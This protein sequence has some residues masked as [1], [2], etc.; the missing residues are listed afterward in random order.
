MGL[1]SPQGKLGTAV[2]WISGVIKN[3]ETLLAIILGAA[4]VWGISGKVES[5]IAAHDAKVFNAGNAQL[6]AQANSNAQQAQTN[7]QL[8]QV[9]QQANAQLQQANAQLSA[10]NAQLSKA[11]A[12]QKAT[13]ATLPPTALA[14][15]MQ[16]L[17]GAPDGS[18]KAQPDNSINLTPPAAIAVTQSLENVPALQAQV[19]NDEKDLAAVNKVLAAETAFANGETDEITGLKKQQ[20]LSDQVCDARVKVEQDKATKAKRKAYVVGG[21]IALVLEAIA[22]HFI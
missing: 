5:I 1:P 15:R 21:T 8:A 16:T 4:L 11:L 18:V 6:Q 12:Q 2:C 7:A 3:H 13:D 10:A 20:L 22:K 14:A 19:A 9:A 17:A